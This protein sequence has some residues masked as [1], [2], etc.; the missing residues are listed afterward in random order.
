LFYKSVKQKYRSIAGCK[1]FY[2]TNTVNRFFLQYLH[3]MF[4]Y[5]S[6]KFCNNSSCIII[7]GMI[8]IKVIHLNN[9]NNYF[10]QVARLSS[11]VDIAESELRSL[12]SHSTWMT[13]DLT[14]V[15]QLA[16]Q[17]SAQKVRPKCL[18]KKG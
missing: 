7:L 10:F 11:K 9:N 12:R 14:D 3:K 18:L 8:K 5:L 16:E 17:L 13:S 6:A 15:H 1:T 4:F 2:L